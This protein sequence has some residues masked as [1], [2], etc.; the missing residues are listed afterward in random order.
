MARSSRLP[1]IRMNTMPGIWTSECSKT[2][3]A[4]RR[5]LVLS[6]EAGGTRASLW[7][8]WGRLRGRLFFEHKK[9]RRGLR[10]SQLDQL[11]PMQQPR[12][13]H[14][15]V[16]PISAIRRAGQIQGPCSARELRSA[17]ALPNYRNAVLIR[18]KAS[19]RFRCGPGRSS[20]ERARPPARSV[21]GHAPADRPARA[22]AICRHPSGDKAG[23]RPS[24]YC[25]ACR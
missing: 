10:R 3:P 8:S 20:G 18:W 23:P 4:T 22:A 19:A 2:P 9:G 16:V 15:G 6:A 7:I 17:P 25:Q 13:P 1:N 12:R 5:G 11:G 14:G 24:G 21:S